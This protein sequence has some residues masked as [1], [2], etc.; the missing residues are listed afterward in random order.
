M[1]TRKQVIYK[2]LENISDVFLNQSSV[3][4]L[5][6]ILDCFNLNK[7]DLFLKQYA[8]CNHICY[9]EN[10]LIRIYYY[11]DG[12]EVTEYFAHEGG[13]FFS[14]ESYFKQIPSYLM[15]EALEP[16]VLYAFPREALEKLCSRNIEIEHLVRK[17]LEGSLIISQKRVFSLL[18]ES[19]QERYN[20]LLK[21]FPDIIRR[22]P[23]VYIASYLGI[24]PETLCR[25]KTAS[26]KQL[27]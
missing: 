6:L 9:V 12:K 4:Q 27:V 26:L 20:N 17:M 3:T 1:E 15:V 24:T 7:H 22:V 16:T 2:I 18:F 11:K 8:V 14:I 5:A 25:V 19:A 10:G 21:S 23:S 13:M